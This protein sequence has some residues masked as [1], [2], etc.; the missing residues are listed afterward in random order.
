MRR[1]PI[2]A[3]VTV[4]ASL[5][6]AGAANA[7]AV[8]TIYRTGAY[9]LPWSADKGAIQA[10]FPGGK[11][12]QDEKGHERYCVTSRQNLLKLP[13]QYDSREL[14]FLVGKDGT[15]ASATAVL[16]PSLQSLLAIVNRCRTTFGDFDAVVRDPQAIQSRYSGQ[17]WTRDAPYVVMV[18]SE[19]DTDGAPV[20]VTYTVADEG[21]LFTDGAAKVSNV[22]ERK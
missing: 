12:D 4:V 3:S 11:W 13:S 22:L 19:N 9:G 8:S 14:C 16:N 20:R 17:L 10:H 2:L 6:T 7:G 1:F 21:N 15:L 18:K 5:L